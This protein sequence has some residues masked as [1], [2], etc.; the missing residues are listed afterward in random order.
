MIA[1][2]QTLFDKA[3]AGYLSTTDLGIVRAFH[4]HGDRLFVHYQPGQLI[5]YNVGEKINFVEE[6]QLGPSLGLSFD[7]EGTRMALQIKSSELHLRSTE[8]CQRIRTESPI[9]S[10][11]WIGKDDLLVSRNDGVFEWWDLSKATMH[12][13][14]VHT[15]ATSLFCSHDIFYAGTETGN[16]KIIK[17]DIRLCTSCIAPSWHHTGHAFLYK[18]NDALIHIWDIRYTSTRAQLCAKA[19]VDQDIQAAFFNDQ[20]L[21]MCR[22]GIGLFVKRPIVSPQGLPNHGTVCFMNTVFQFINW[23]PQLREEILQSTNESQLR[24]ILR[25]ILDQLESPSPIK[26]DQHQYLCEEVL[27]LIGMER[28][29]HQDALEFLLILMSGTSCSIVKCGP[30][31]TCQC[32]TTDESDGS[33][34]FFWLRC[35]ESTFVDAKH[36]M[37]RLVAVS[38]EKQWVGRC[39]VCYS[40]KYEE[41]RFQQPLPNWIFFQILRQPDEMFQPLDFPFNMKL[42]FDKGKLVMIPPLL[43]VYGTHYMQWY[44]L[45]DE[46]AETYND[47]DEV[48]NAFDQEVQA[49]CT[50][51][52]ALSYRIDFALKGCNLQ[53]RPKDEQATQLRS[54]LM[55]SSSIRYAGRLYSTTAS[56][57]VSMSHSQ[58]GA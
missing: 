58:K 15:V 8:V 11:V 52:V 48:R 21:T 17:T 4:L 45:N 31:H 27:K 24:R 47:S 44:K 1:R 39:I 19:A 23:N 35:N 33:N 34:P 9:A 12:E 50:S 56:R 30:V 10:F 53:R 37:E 41:Y 29:G 57:T 13:R 46:R 54:T 5:R 38:Q 7:H 22:S 43:S 32:S 3:R 16:K 6:Y 20:V 36:T 25:K 49:A 51:V 55:D 28:Q 42:R 26:K 18:S 2:F 40:D 14:S